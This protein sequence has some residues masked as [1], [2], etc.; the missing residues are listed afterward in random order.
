MIPAQS[1]HL[2][3]A[4]ADCD[5]MAPEAGG[6]ATRFLRCVLHS[7]SWAAGQ[8]LP[9]EPRSCAEL[10]ASLCFSTSLPIATELLNE[11]M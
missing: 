8:V 6:A 2:C 9:E 5:S 11:V 1:C 10:V 4:V 7:Q 3:A